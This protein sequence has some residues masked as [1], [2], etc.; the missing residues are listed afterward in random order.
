MFYVIYAE[1][2]ILSPSE[3]I[4]RAIIANMISPDYVFCYI[5]RA[6]GN[7]EKI[8]RFLEKFGK[9]WE[10]LFYNFQSRRQILMARGVYRIIISNVG[11]K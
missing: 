1:L 10:I 7:F 11:G 5:P 4:L 9:F 6:N 8:L 2:E 3:P